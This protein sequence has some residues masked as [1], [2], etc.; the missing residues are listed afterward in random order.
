MVFN[1]ANGI[2]TSQ[3][4]TYPAY[5]IPADV[6]IEDVNMDALN[7]VL[8][9]HRGWRQVGLFT[10]K[11]NGTLNPYRLFPAP[12]SGGWSPQGMDVGDLN[13][14]GYPDIVIA[15]S[16]DGIGV[17]YHESAPDFELVYSENTKLVMPGSSVSFRF[18]V[19]SY[20][21]FDQPVN[22]TLT[23]LPVG[24]TYDFSPDS[25]IPP[26]SIDLSLSV[27]PAVPE[28]TYK[29]TINS[30]SGEVNHVDDI[31]LI[32]RKPITTLTIESDGPAWS[33][34]PIQFI[35]QADGTETIYFWDF[36]DGQYGYANPASHVF[37]GLGAYTV[38]VHASNSVSS[39]DAQLIVQVV[40]QP[41][42]GLNIGV[43][44]PAYARF[45]VVFQA[46]ISAGTHPQYVWD[47]G[48]GQ[49]SSGAQV[50]HVF[51]SP[52]DYTVQVTSFNGSGQQTDW[53][54]VHVLK[55]FVQFIPLLMKE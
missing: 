24:I 53:V 3:E 37:S 40:D 55:P 21:G 34:V 50:S 25:I 47:F 19:E 46:V 54:T 29:I 28:G 48:D 45:P 32:V 8:V 6:E 17:L 43:S 4:A 12:Y 42:A 18:S 13:H 26:G 15:D 33:G 49:Q 2:P 22:F 35:A 10:Q 1:F 44:T 31:W 36:G 27:D 23:G 14:D 41:I 11:E 30:I 52:G 5:D 20:Y 39:M 16:G 51:L 7:D 38:T 9:L